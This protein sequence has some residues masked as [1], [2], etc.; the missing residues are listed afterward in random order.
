MSRLTTALACFVGD[1]IDR[2]CKFLLFVVLGLR[3]PAARIREHDLATNREFI[4]AQLLESIGD[5]RHW[6]NELAD[7]DDTLEHATRH[8]QGL[9]ERR[10][11]LLNIPRRRADTETAS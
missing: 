10:E 2:A 11:A 8:S 6:M 7:C 9:V 4:E 3:L 5:V 1:R